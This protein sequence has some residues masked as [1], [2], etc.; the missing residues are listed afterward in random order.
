ML[1]FD[2]DFRPLTASLNRAAAE[3][4][5]KLDEL[6]LKYTNKAAQMLRRALPVSDEPGKT[7]IRD[8]VAVSKDEKGDYVVSYGSDES[9]AL[10]IEIGHKDKSGGWVPGARAGRSV[11]SQIRKQY[12][13]A[14][15]RAVNNIVKPK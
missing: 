12:R 9:P 4:K 15:R 1:E 13:G 6:R 14:A 5:T 8:T 3:A 10:P 11:M 7:H 2:A